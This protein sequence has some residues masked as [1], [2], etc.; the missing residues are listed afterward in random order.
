[1]LENFVK[2]NPRCKWCPAPGCSYALIL[3]EVSGEG[4]EAVVCKCGH[5]FWYASS[6][7]AF[8][9]SHARSL[10]SLLECSF[11]CLAAD[12]RP[13]SCAMAVEWT[14]KNSGGDDTLNQVCILTIA[15][16]CP[17]CKVNIQKNE[18]CNHMT[19]AHCHYHFCWNCMG[20][21]G[22][23]PK[24]GTDG[25]G[26]HKCNGD[27]TEGAASNDSVAELKRFEFFSNRYNNHHRSGQ[28]EARL[29]GEVP[30]L[31]KEL[32]DRFGMPWIACQ[33]FVTGV[34]QLQLNRQILK[35]SYM[36]GYFRSTMAPYVNKDIFEN[37]QLDLERHTE[38]L[39]NLLGY[40]ITQ[41]MGWYSSFT[42]LHSACW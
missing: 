20:K 11:R 19:C 23:G 14:K 25:Y 29:L 34:Q 40:A 18:G 41:S 21:F 42:H 17:S 16:P 33:F 35:N 28:L 26:S 1:M 3:H 32:V 5:R 10:N 37:I 24:G 8:T 2:S 4:N 39:S 12:H 36:F 7:G 6:R 15:R 31:E 22:S 9:P 30:L 13:A 38:R 27:Y